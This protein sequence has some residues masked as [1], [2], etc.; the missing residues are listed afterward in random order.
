[1]RKTIVFLLIVQFA[2]NLF[3]QTTLSG[4]LT[5]SNGTGVGNARLI[6]LSI[7]DTVIYETYSDEFGDYEFL[8]IQNITNIDNDSLVFLPYNINNKY[9]CFSEPVLFKVYDISGRLIDTR[10]TAKMQFQSTLSGFYFVNVAYNQAMIRLNIVLFNGNISGY[11]QIF[12]SNKNQETIRTNTIEQKERITQAVNENEWQVIVEKDCHQPYE[13]NL[14]LEEIDNFANFQIE[15][16]TNQ[17]KIKYCIR[18]EEKV[19][20]G[21]MYSYRYYES[22]F[23]TVQSI[24]FLEIDL[25][26]DSIALQIGYKEAGLIPYVSGRAKTSTFA[27]NVNALAGING[28]F[29]DLSGGGGSVCFLKVNNEIITTSIG[30]NS[31]IE[32]GALAFTA[33]DTNTCDVAVLQRPD[34]LWTDSS[35][36]YENIITSGPMLINNDS[37]VNTGGWGEDDMNSR[38]AIGITEDN[39]LMFVVVDGEREE[40]PGVICSQLKGIM[41]ALDCKYALNFD[42]GGSS[43]MYIKAKEG[44]EDQFGLTYTNGVVN[45]PDDNGVFDHNF[46]RGVANCILIMPN[47]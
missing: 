14:Q 42:G 37:I 17:E 44:D 23:D 35:C 12:H 31:M 25:N 46:E 27:Q 1:M 39:K 22:L 21:L 4:S 3:T 6:L 2:N 5:Y 34:S 11:K 40:A 18:N 41:Q 24:S 36:S 16:P 38:T 19:G 10:T 47:Y 32:Q 26:N 13:F 20:P 15:I 8:D 7:T 29:F 43:T 9:I 30:T 33:Q 28:T 45:Y